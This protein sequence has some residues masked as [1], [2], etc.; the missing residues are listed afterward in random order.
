[1]PVTAKNSTA[2]KSKAA[3]KASANSRTSD[4]K[5]QGVVNVKGASARAKAKNFD[6][7]RRN[8]AN[9]NEL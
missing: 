5:K 3:A 9:S 4:A 7:G 6:E 8:D 1:M 2:T